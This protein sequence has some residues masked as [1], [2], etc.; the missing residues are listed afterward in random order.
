M[1]VKQ[2]CMALCLQGEVW[3]HLLSALVGGDGRE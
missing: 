3:G 1:E 2:A